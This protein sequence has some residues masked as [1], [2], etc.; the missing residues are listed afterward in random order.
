VFELP[1]LTVLP[2]WVHP[3]LLEDLSLVALVSTALVALLAFRFIRRL[4]FRGVILGLLLL[5]AVGL[6]EQR[7]QLS[8]CVDHC[9]CTIF[10]QTVQIPADRVP[11]CGESSPNPDTNL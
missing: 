11:G 1:E 9:A 2:S 6:W 7:A 4:A 5:L 3:E 8:D 10:G